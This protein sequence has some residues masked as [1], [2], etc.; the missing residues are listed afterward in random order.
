ME[1]RPYLEK[2]QPLVWRTFTN[3]LK[4]KKVGHAYLLLGEAGIPLKQVAVF[5][6]K[7]LLC[8]HPNPLACESCVTCRRIEK[9]EYPDYFFFDGAESSIKKD[10]VT[11][12]TAM[13]S[14]SALEEKG[15]MVYVINEVENM[16]PDAANS[17]LKFL[18]EPTE[19]TYAILTSKN[20]AKVLPTIISRCET[21]RML[22]AP[23]AQVIQDAIACGAP[24]EDAEMLSYFYNSGELVAE[25]AASESYQDAKSVFAPFLEALAD[26]PGIARYTIQKDVTPALNGKPALRFFFDML[27]LV[28]QDVVAKKTGSP[29]SLSAYDRIIGDLAENLPHV[30]SSLLSVMTLRGEIETNINGGLLLSHLVSV[31]TKE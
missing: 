25:E 29:I 21:V 26:N 17:L 5:L 23:R 30:E 31:I 1:V 27:T 15:I 19:G 8:D 2:H 7:S 9:E 24:Q 4:S 16:T 18:E 14:Q 10:D 22:L 11:T 6:A 20:E 28:F 3:A 13:F 12:V